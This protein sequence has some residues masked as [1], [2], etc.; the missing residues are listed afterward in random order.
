MDG[1]SAGTAIMTAVYS[2][3]FGLPLDGALA[4][5]GEVSIFGNVLPV[6]GVGAKIN[7]AAN[8]GIKRVVIPKENFKSIYNEINGI[9]IITAES[10]ED[11][12]LA[13]FP[14]K[15]RKKIVEN[16]PVSENIDTISAIGG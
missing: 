5:T 1:P 13:V 9:E 11:V 6:G 15:A 8:A 2:A 3:F 12:I 7:A 10:F 4:L 16:I 14:G